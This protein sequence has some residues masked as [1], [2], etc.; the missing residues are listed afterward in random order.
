MHE[1]EELDKQLKQPTIGDALGPLPRDS[2]PK[3]SKVPLID[4]PNWKDGVQITLFERFVLL[5]R[6]N[7]V[8]ILI[9]AAKV[10]GIN[11]SPLKL[12]V[13]NMLASKSWKT[14]SAGIVLVVGGAIRL[15]F[16]IKAGNITEEAIT[17]S[18]T[19][20]LSGIGL[21]FARDNDKSSEDVGA[22]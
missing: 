3:A 13:V 12:R 8:P 9:V 19:G 17:T 1:F 10:V 15:Y 6:T 14:T 11:L 16:A 21:I 2:K 4:V 7:I 18:L 20:I 5:V 22:V